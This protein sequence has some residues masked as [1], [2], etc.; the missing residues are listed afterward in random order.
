MTQID[1]VQ[2]KSDGK[3]SMG[4]L[5]EYCSVVAESFLN[6]EHFSE[7]VDVI[8][9]CCAIVDF[10][11]TTDEPSPEAATLQSDRPKM[12]S[13]AVEQSHLDRYGDFFKEYQ[14]RTK[15]EGYE[16]TARD[17]L[18]IQKSRDF[19]TWQKTSRNFIMNESLLGLISHNGNR[20]CA[21]MGC[22]F[23]GSMQMKMVF[24]QVASRPNKRSLLCEILPKP[25]P[26]SMKSVC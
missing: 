24:Q 19:A 1:L 15:Q 8:M 3:C 14:E 20:V 7:Y 12:R 23:H 4:M 6:Q 25:T 2:R 21:V 5:R 16:P 10:I 26:M 18:S 17:Q 11:A 13:V 22:C 9:S